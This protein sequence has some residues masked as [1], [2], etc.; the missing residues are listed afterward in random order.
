MI[1]RDLGCLESSP[2]LGDSGINVGFAMCSSSVFSFSIDFQALM[3]KQGQ[4]ATI[5]S[6]NKEK[7]IFHQS[8][9]NMEQIFNLRI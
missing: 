7:K 6:A 9:I 1:E 5:R 2:F 3:N 4:A 8:H